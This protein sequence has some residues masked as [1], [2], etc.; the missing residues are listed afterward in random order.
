MVEQLIPV[1]EKA[2]AL[3]NLSQHLQRSCAQSLKPVDMTSLVGG[4]S[5]GG[6]GSGIDNSGSNGGGTPTTPTIVNPGELTV[7]NAVQ[8]QLD[9][10]V[11]ASNLDSLVNHNGILLHMKFVPE[12][13]HAH[14]VKLFGV[15]C[16]FTCMNPLHRCLDERGVPIPRIVKDCLDYLGAHGSQ[17]EGL[18]RVSGSAKGM[19]EAKLKW[20]NAEMTPFDQM[21]SVH[22][23]AGLL[24][25]YFRQLP[26]P[27]MESALYDRVRQVFIGN[28]TDDDE[29]KAVKVRKIIN[30]L[31]HG[32]YACLERLIAFGHKLQK[33]EQ[34]TK[35]NATN[36]AICITPS[37]LAP[38][39]TMEDTQNPQ[40]M[41]RY[42]QEKSQISH[43]VAF[44]IT[45]YSQIFTRD[46]PY[47]PEL[48]GLESEGR[49]WRR[50]Q[51]AFDAETSGT[52]AVDVISTSHMMEYGALNPMVIIELG[53]QVVQTR[54][55]KEQNDPLFL[56][57]FELAVF[58]SEVEEMNVYVYSVEEQQVCRR[59]RRR[60]MAYSFLGMVVVPLSSASVKREQIRVKHNLSH[61]TMP[62]TIDLALT[63]LNYG[64]ERGDGTK[65]SLRAKMGS[66]GGVS[67]RSC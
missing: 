67:P 40:D 60:T 26:D 9:K 37:I 44:M 35:M 42:V 17:T 57:Q 36:V 66:R 29:T 24:K 58:N 38:P 59:T 27:L 15:P 22:D 55:V 5:S 45:H 6:G 19:E 4:G 23:V 56:E 12:I 51:S 41:M 52:L 32:N 50:S 30:T 47:D 33:N 39:P 7:A 48:K 64:A 3:F 2:K 25:L 20:D 14:F 21:T 61:G 18:L 31:P 28:T 43:A 8:H 16:E 62:G 1:S 34:S 63:P 11:G 53:G 13:D 46:S 65:R 49:G 10:C 54:V